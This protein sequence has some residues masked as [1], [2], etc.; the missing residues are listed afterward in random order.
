MARLAAFAGSQ[1]HGHN[2]FDYDYSL[3]VLKPD[4]A[5]AAEFRRDATDSAMRTRQSGDFAFSG[6]FY[7]HPVFR[8]HFFPN[9][10][11]ADTWRTIYVADWSAQWAHRTDWKPLPAD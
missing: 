1:K 11:T 7:F 4:F 2:K 10:V 6:Q 8:E 5:I 3:G 9:P